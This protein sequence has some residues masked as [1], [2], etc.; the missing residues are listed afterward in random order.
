[1]IFPSTLDVSFRNF[2]DPE[3]CV[4]LSDYFFPENARSQL[5]VL[6]IRPLIV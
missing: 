2:Q 1:M 3:Q 4:Q 6:V 5:T